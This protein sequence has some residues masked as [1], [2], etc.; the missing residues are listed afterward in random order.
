MPLDRHD[1]DNKMVES[2]KFIARTQ[3]KEA[4]TELR[5][6]AADVPEMTLDEINAEIS[7]IHK[8]RSDKR[9]VI[10]LFSSFT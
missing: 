5:R 1:A 10:S 8:E 4:F 7:A 6:L 9:N 3:A 2:N